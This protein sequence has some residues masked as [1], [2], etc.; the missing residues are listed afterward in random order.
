MAMETQAPSV[1]MVTLSI[2]GKEVQVPKGTNVIEAARKIGIDIPYLCYHHQ[3]T[4]FGGCRLCLVEVEKVPKLLAACNTI[5]AD[6]MVVR[7]TGEKVK[8]Q[9]SGSLEF[10]L[11]N[12]PLDC[13]VCDK[14]GE[15]ELQDRTFEYSNGL[16][17]MTEPKVHVEDYDLGPLIVR[18]QDRCIICKRCV[19]VMEEIVGEPV[20]EFGQRGVTTEVYTFEH[21]QF[22]PGFSGNTIRVC[23]VG[24]LMS[25][26]F[27][28]KSRPWELIKTPSICSLCSVGCNLREDVRENKLLRVV[29]LENPRV[30][31]AWLC[32]RGQFGYDYVNSPDR[33]TAPLI[34]RSGGQLEQ[35][36]WE[37]ALTLVAR[38]LK[39]VR[40]SS[41]GAAFGAIGSE[42]TSNE[43][44][45]ALQQ[46]TRD[47]MGSPN[48]D[49][50]MGSTRASYQAMRPK[51]GAIEALP[52]S[53]VVLA[54]GTDLTADTPVLD[55]VLKRSLLPKKMKLV[56]ANPRATG[57]NKFAHQWLRYTPGQEIALLN[58]LCRALIEEGLVP[59]EVRAGGAGWE[60]VNQG[61]AVY[62][63]A[64]LAAIAGASE[65]DV[66]YAARL[67]ADAR[68]G[69]ILYSQSAV[70]SRDGAYML[71]ALQNLSIL[72]GQSL[73]PGHVLLEA[74][75]EMNTWGARDMGVLPD[76]GPGGAKVSRGMSTGEMLQGVMDGKIRAL[77]VMGSNPLVE[78][79]GAAKAL[80]A[81][82]TVEFLVVQD[83]F[84]TETA[85]L[86]HVVLPAVSVA[87]RNCTVTNVEGRAQRTVRA[88]DPR[89]AAK[90]EW[91]VLGMLAE[92]MGEPLGYTT[93][94]SVTRRV[95]EAVLQAAAG[96]GPRT[97]QRVETPQP[98]S[99]DANF[100]M[101]LFTGKLMFDR[102]T[103]QRRSTVLPALAP[104]P[105]IEINPADAARF[106][107][108]DG[109]VAAVYTAY[110]RMELPAR[111]SADTPPG[112]VFIPSGYNDT[113]VTGIL[114]EGTDVVACRLS[115]PEG[116]GGG[117]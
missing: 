43:D 28:F 98:R 7:T 85:E 80:K 61:L 99:T 70:D 73:K 51:P 36:S 19:K 66:R 77:Y 68:T 74:V 27:R 49:H 20:L 2:D 22:K 24:A 45:F 13:P 29:G 108:A 100:P 104:D 41:G 8:S 82:Q 79:P 115:R 38:K 84:M 14:G 69:S 83:M 32:D 71:A 46:F 56:V 48:V 107:V 10:I 18:N 5:V 94:E 9:R 63:L 101:L 16:S 40:E 102:S 1:P 67:F 52:G 57:L 33:L 26:P 25:K 95:R 92:D 76:A 30:N 111:V 87:E 65:E 64:Q 42:R 81:L 89:G 114:T 47:V 117:Q 31:D 93:P 59:E 39:E 97:L 34:R 75:R 6:G 50:R 3:L 116:A 62:S 90:Q 110:G 60:A 35:A 96:A 23:P 54:I 58:A 112:C 53:D 17:R 113:P 86:A 21:E 106:A 88:L 78:F 15:C 44:S 11:L 37:E 72:S 91:Q 4:S 55:L 103:I 12:H 105:F 109:E